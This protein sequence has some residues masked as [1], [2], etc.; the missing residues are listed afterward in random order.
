MSTSSIEHLEQRALRERQEL[1]QRATELKSKVNMVR[2]NLDIHR[3]ARRYFGPAAGVLA[4]VG[5]L[6][7]YAVAGLF[8]DH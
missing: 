1:H 2:E 3:N 5:L 4:V 6:S 7:G 8:T